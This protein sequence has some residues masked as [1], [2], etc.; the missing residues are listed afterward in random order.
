MFEIIFVKVSFSNN[1]NKLYLQG[2]A[3]YLHRHDPVV[4]G[5]VY[6]FPRK[7]D[8]KQKWTLCKKNN[9]KKTGLKTYVFTCD[10]YHPLTRQVMRS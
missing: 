3:V 2:F 1:P 6:F 9:K 4:L 5:F 10:I 7:H 8:S